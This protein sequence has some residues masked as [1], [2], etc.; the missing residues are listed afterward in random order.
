MSFCSCVALHMCLLFEKRRESSALPLTGATSSSSPLASRR[1]KRRA[2]PKRPHVYCAS[3]AVRHALDPVHPRSR[4]NNASRSAP[5]PR[6]VIRRWPPIIPR[7]GKQSVRPKRP[8]RQPRIW[9][10]VYCVLLVVLPH[11]ICLRLA[12]PLC[13]VQPCTHRNYARR[14]AP[15]R[16]RATKRWPPLVPRGVKRSARTGLLACGRLCIVFCMRC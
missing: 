7:V 15:S 5:P 2:R 6:R 8:Y 14:S 3:F 4:L 10:H 12:M 9:L 11:T 13:R 16:R 1:F